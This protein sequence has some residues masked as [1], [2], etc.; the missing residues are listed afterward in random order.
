MCGARVPSRGRE[1]EIV[2]GTHFGRGDSMLAVEWWDLDPSDPE[3]RT[4]KRWT[5]PAGSPKQ[6]VLNSTEL[7]MVDFTME[8]G[9]KVMPPL[10]RRSGRARVASGKAKAGRTETDSPAGRTQPTA[11]LQR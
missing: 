5:P 4:Y 8:G 7:R 10:V 2:D 3:K 9:T 1:L 11:C 6:F